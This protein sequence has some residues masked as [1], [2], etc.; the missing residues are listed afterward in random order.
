M[1]HNKYFG[2]TENSIK[3][4][5]FNISITN[6][7]AN[8]EILKHSH[9][10]PYLCLLV[11]GIYNEKSN[12]DNLVSCGDVIYRTADYEHS[13]SFYDKDSLCL[14][15]E[16]NN[17]EHLMNQNNFVLPTSQSKQKGRIEIYKVL[18]ALKQRLPN[19]LLDI[20]CYESMLTHIKMSRIKGNLI[21]IKEIKEIINDNPT[22][23]LSLEKLSLEF[24]L[25]PNYIVRKF[26]EVTGHKLS[27]YLTKIRLENSIKHLIKTESS[28]T[29]IAIN[30]G[31]YDQSHF[32]RNFKNYL[33]TTPLTFRKIVKG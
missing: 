4:E 31:F 25:H 33:A 26:K 5:S 16:I 19:D 32:N 28:M 23:P 29:E 22:S 1:K 7:L 18:Y 11:S 9:A 24:G 13:N 17:Q 6:H 20:Y 21:W 30:A 27:D 10:K 8:S 2:T 14:N 12:I 15:I 3:T